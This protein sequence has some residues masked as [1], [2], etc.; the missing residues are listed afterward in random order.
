M[1]TFLQVNPT[2]AATVAAFLTLT[3]LTAAYFVFEP[4]VAYGETDVFTVSQDIDTEIAFISPANDVIMTPAIEGITG[5]NSFG[6]STVAVNTNN[7]DGYNMSIQFATGTALQGENIPSDIPNYQPAVGG[8]PDYNFAVA[9]NSAGFAYSVN[10]TTNAA[11]LDSIFWNNGSA[12]NAGTAG[13]VGHCWY[14]MANAVTPVEIINRSTATPSTGA[15]T[16]IVFQVGVEANP[17]PA[18]QTGTYTATATLTALV[19]P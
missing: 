11:D 4:V 17:S 18:I 6:T 5:G 13:S 1:R 19:N 2:V 12:C 10:A 15:T 16:T 7:P 8:T 14:N 3:I 9:A